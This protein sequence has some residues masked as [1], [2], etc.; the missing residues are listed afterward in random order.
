MK[1]ISIRPGVRDSLTVGEVPSP[2]PNEGEL[3]VQSLLTG[4]CGT[5][6]EL[7][8][9][10][11][12]AAAP[13]GEE[14]LILG[15]E[16]FGAVV[17]APP[18]SSFKRGDLVVGVVRRP[19]PAP[20]ASCAAGEWDMCQNGKFTERG[21]K[22]RHGY[23]SEQ[24]VLEEA[25][26]IAVP[27]SL[28]ETGVLIEPTSVVAKAWEQID[29]M[30]KRLHAYKP[31]RTLITG[32]GPIGLL[33]ALLAKQ[34]EHDIVVYDRATSG[35]KPDLVRALGATY[36][37]DLSQLKEPPEIVVECTGAA[38]VVLDVLQRVARNGIVCLTGL[39][40]GKRTIEL[41]VRNFNDA[42]VLENEVVFG[43]VNANIRHYEAARD[44]LSL[45]PAEWLARLITRRV[46]LAQFAEAYEARADDI[47]VVI[48]WQA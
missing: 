18:S 44:A 3:L 48:D 33:A 1:A 14:C 27:G 35:T 47:K 34:R 4:I 37:H 8:E 26:A 25:F 13:E 9:G 36:C 11:Q 23:A 46:P 2:K 10:Q 5:D 15:H 19:D 24:F 30:A 31:R 39:S 42:L 41:G 6:R 45:A 12:P 29:F 20:C 43:T 21:I 22:Q 7:I 28:R 40:S 32:A 16:S 17:S 38:V